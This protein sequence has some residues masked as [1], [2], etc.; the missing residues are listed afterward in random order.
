M[1]T[2]C[3]SLYNFGIQNEA[4]DVRAHVCP[5]V[6]KIYV[7]PTEEGRKTLHRG[8][9]KKRTAYQ[10]GVNGATALGYLVPPFAIPRCI[11]LE[12]RVCTWDAIGFDEN[13]DTTDKGN[14]AVRLVRA[15]ILNGL[16]PLPWKVNNLDVVEE[17]SVQIDGDDIIVTIGSFTTHIQVKCDYRGGDKSLGGTGNLF[18]QIAERNPLGKI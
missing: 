17:K 15:M 16:F 13:D 18:L 1:A 5:L 12:V 6:Q 7:F 10:P 9:W 3:N 14:K 4:S 2:N 11:A 8:Q